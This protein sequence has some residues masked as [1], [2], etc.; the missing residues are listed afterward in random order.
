MCGSQIEALL[1]LTAIVKPTG[2]S[3]DGKTNVKFMNNKKSHFFHPILSMWSNGAPGGAPDGGGG[4]G[5]WIGS[6]EAG[7]LTHR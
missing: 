5:G 2:T 7:G 1:V 3:N 6:T 4:G